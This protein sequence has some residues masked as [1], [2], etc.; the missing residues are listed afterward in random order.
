DAALRRARHAGR[1]GTH[2]DGASPPGGTAET[3]RSGG[4]LRRARQAPGGDQA[5]AGR[6]SSRG[7]ATGEGRAHPGGDCGQGT[8][9]GGGRGC[10]GGDRAD[11]LGAETFSRGGASHGGGRR[12]G[13]RG[14]TQGSHSRRQGLGFRVSA[15]GDP[16]VVPNAASSSPE[17]KVRRKKEPSVIR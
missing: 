3:E 2:R 12:R 6:A 7:D 1:A 15:R 4:G 5:A 14:R 10:L 11:G 13:I 16:E 9:D 8:A 17:T